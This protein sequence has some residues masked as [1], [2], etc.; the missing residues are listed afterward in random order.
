MDNKEILKWCI[1]K[2]ILL[3]AETLKLLNESGDIESV[4]I[5]LENIKNYTQTRVITKRLFQTHKEK[6]EEFFS[7]LPKENQRKLEKFKIKLGL[8][9]EISK[10]VSIERPN[11][12]KSGTEIISGVIEEEL[13]VKVLS[14]TPSFKKK[15]VVDDFIKHFRNRFMKLKNILQDR[16]ELDQ[17]VSINKL[18]SSRKKVSIIGMISNKRITKNKNILLDVEDFTG[19]TRVLISESKEETFEKAENLALDSVIGFN[20][21]GDREITFVNEIVLPES[22]LFERKKSPVDENVLFMGDLHYG[23]KYFFEKDFLKFIDYLNGKTKN[24]FEV[25]KIK[26]LFVGGDLVAGVGNYPNQEKDLK[27]KNIEDQFQGLADIF[28]RIK[29]D[30]K[31]IISPGNHDGVRLME[32]QPVLDEKYAW[33]LYN[34]K[35]VILTGNPAFVNIGAKKDFSGFDVL[36]YHGF[37]FPYYANNIPKLIKSTINSPEKIMAYLLQKRHLAPAFSSV[38]TLPAD[39]DKLVI[40]KVPDI[41]VAGHIHKCALTYYNNILLVSNSGWEDA[42]EYQKRFG[43]KPDFCKVSMFN[44][45]TRVVKILDF[46][47]EKTGRLGQ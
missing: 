30:I 37:S 43:N 13:S 1:G 17:L 47:G 18:P 39:E 40:D 32:P 10:E 42:T 6:T 44:L 23:S 9:I 5:I 28:S 11:S 15:I 29:K 7:T 31:I 46:E 36:S 26:Y 19:K 14:E 22:L 38:Q 27:I 45:K 12:Q 24:S 21:F 33:P 41:F 16:S 8:E 25:D 34:L 3:D 2:G 20:G 4:K 35:N